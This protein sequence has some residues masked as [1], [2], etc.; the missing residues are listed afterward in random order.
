VEEENEERFIT[1]EEEATIYP[2]T[3]F[4]PVLYMGTVITDW[5]MQCFVLVNMCSTTETIK[6]VVN[7]LNKHYCCQ[8]FTALST[9]IGI[10]V[11][12]EGTSV[13][14]LVLVGVRT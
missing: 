7:L 12:V 5:A 3:C 13:L 1:L 8:V 2:H 10:V 14:L 6:E 11:T 4:L 9:W